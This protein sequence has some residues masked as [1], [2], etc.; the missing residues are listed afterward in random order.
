MQ[1]NHLQTVIWGILQAVYNVLDASSTE[2]NSVG[3][4]TPTSL[5]LGRAEPTPNPISRRKLQLAIDR[6]V[7]PVEAHRQFITQRKQ[8]IVSPPPIRLKTNIIFSDRFHQLIAKPPL[9]AFW[10]KASSVHRCRNP[11]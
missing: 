10:A 3:F 9:S 7:A 1:W 6:H 2:T 8:G 11:M 4:H 5:G